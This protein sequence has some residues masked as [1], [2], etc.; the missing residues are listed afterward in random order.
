MAMLFSH[1]KSSLD[2]ASAWRIILASYIPLFFTSA[3]SA[4]INPCTYSTHTP[5]MILT[6]SSAIPLS[7]E[8]D[9]VGTRC[10]LGARRSPASHRSR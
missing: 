9:D 3:V 2:D 7:Y 6:L 5:Q 4:D 1:S 10:A 8:E